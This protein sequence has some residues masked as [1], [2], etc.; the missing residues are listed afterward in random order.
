MYNTIS[1]ICLNTICG[2]GLNTNK[3]FHSFYLK[4][5]FLQN[6]KML[7]KGKVFPSEENNSNYT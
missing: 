6:E 1:D 2:V 4:S 7:I 3:L 5:T